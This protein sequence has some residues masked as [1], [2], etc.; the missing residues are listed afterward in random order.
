MRPSC[1]RM[2]KLIKGPLFT[3]DLHGEVNN[4]SVLIIE[5]SPEIAHVE[6]AVARAAGCVPRVAQSA[7]EAVDLLELGE[8]D[9]ILLGSPVHLSEDALVLDLL[10]RRLRHCARRTVVVTSHIYDGQVTR[11]AASANV[12]AVLAKPFDVSALADLLWECAHNNGAEGPTRWVG[13]SEPHSH[14]PDR[15]TSGSS[16]AQVQ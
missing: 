7:A 8:F 5:E 1:T 14:A 16:D 13:L 10:T 11:L 9:V 3:T 4:A 12:Y 6:R 15:D 2:A